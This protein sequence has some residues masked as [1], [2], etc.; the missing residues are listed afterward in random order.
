MKRAISFILMLC[1]LHMDAAA[2]AAA[3]LEEA[4][5]VQGLEK[6]SQ[7]AFDAGEGF[8]AAVYGEYAYIAA[9]DGGLQVVDSS[10]PH[11]AKTVTPDNRDLQGTAVTDGSDCVAVHGDSLFAA[12]TADAD[13]AA[14]PQIRQYSLK[15]P[16]APSLQKVFEMEAEVR[17]IA[18]KEQYMFAADY[19]S[20]IKVY[21]LSNGENG[22][23]QQILAGNLRGGCLAVH[24]RRLALCGVYRRG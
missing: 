2:F 12:F 15:N 10:D 7:A 1:M 9:K 23:H 13:G 5:P 14:A 20:G 6:L 21:D 16:A 11:A 22:A 3:G 17:D 8:T 18:F 19:R 4:A 24:Q